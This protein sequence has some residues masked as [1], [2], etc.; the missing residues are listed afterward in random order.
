M[1][2]YFLDWRNDFPSKMLGVQKLQLRQDLQ[3]AQSWHMEHR[4]NTW[5]LALF[6]EA[7]IWGQRY[8][9][10]TGILG[11]G[12]SVLNLDF[13]DPFWDGLDGKSNMLILPGLKIKARKEAAIRV[14][15]L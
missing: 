15:M 14:R 2:L 7:Q 4:S 6:Q 3:Q 9:P 1:R 12:F 8:S 5:R 13:I 10:N 11:I